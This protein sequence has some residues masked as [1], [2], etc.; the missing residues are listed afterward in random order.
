MLNKALFFIGCFLTATIFLA[1]VG[2]GLIIVSFLITKKKEE[3]KVNHFSKEVL[4]QFR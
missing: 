3:P 1:P 4:E 2:I